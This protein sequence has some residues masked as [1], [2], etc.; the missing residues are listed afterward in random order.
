[1]LDVILEAKNHTATAKL[2]EGLGE[3]LLVPKN[4]LF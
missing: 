3:A 1:M 2:A 4:G